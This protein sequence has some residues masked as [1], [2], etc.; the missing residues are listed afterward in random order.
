MVPIWSLRGPYV[1]PNLYLHT[2]LGLSLQALTWTLQGPYLIP[3]LFLADML[4]PYVVLVCF[5]PLFCS[6]LV[7]TQSLRYSY[8]ICLVPTWSLCGLYDSM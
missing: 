2:L 1:V 3:T 4:S 7:H 5:F 6:Y 8:L